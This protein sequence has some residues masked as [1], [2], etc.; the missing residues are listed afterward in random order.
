MH[1][2]IETHSH[3]Q[4]DIQYKGK[5][6]AMELRHE[7]KHTQRYT[8]AQINM[9]SLIFLSGG[10]FLFLV[11]LERQRRKRLGES[12]RLFHPVMTTT[13]GQQLS[14]THT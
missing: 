9:L 13:S 5:G 4:A 7:P 8:N 10:N 11:C 2:H 1:T 6:Q 14:L 3:I 12:E